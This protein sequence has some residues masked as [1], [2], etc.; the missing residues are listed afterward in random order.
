MGGARLHVQ[1]GRPLLFHC[2]CLRMKDVDLQ[3][4]GDPQQPI[5]GLLN[6]ACGYGAFSQADWPY[7]HVAALSTSNPVAISGL[8]QKNGCGACIEVTCQASYLAGTV[9]RT[10]RSSHTCCACSAVL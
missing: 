1:N 6:G 4:G 3:E 7:W 8:P 2:M 5:Y 10:S 9:R